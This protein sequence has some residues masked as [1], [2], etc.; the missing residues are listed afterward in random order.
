MLERESKTT[1][2]PTPPHPTHTT[3]FALDHHKVD[4]HTTTLFCGKLPTTTP[5]K[6]FAHQP[7]TLTLT[8]ARSRTTPDIRRTRINM[9]SLYFAE[10]LEM[11]STHM[12]SQPNTLARCDLYGDEPVAATKKHCKACSTMIMT[13]KRT[14]FCASASG[15]RK[16]RRLLVTRLATIRAWKT[17]TGCATTIWAWALG[18]GMD[19]GNGSHKLQ[20]VEKAPRR[21]SSHRPRSMQVEHDVI[22]RP[23]AVPR[24][25]AAAGRGQ[26]F[27][28]VLS[29]SRP[30][31]DPHTDLTL[32]TPPT[33][34][35]PTPTTSPA[36]PHGHS[37]RFFTAHSNEGCLRT[38]TFLC[39]LP[40]SPA[41]FI[42]HQH[43]LH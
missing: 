29:I 7:H 3:D 6:N 28:C 19:M 23:R 5:H 9:L 38:D 26:H 18:M 37:T 13:L 17:A 39:R 33:P 27:M 25:R 2:P 14:A 1:P 20:F 15:H 4:R 22:R 43:L 35:T 16:S 41:S 36:Q 12:K 32:H 31:A 30:S 34:P 21:R 42:F 10:C 40:L 8:H 11:L 24:V